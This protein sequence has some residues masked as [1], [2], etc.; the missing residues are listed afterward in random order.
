MNPLILLHP[1]LLRIYVVLV[2]IY[3]GMIFFGFIG[4]EIALPMWK[5]RERVLTIKEAM[6]HAQA[7]HYKA[8]LKVTYVPYSKNKLKITYPNGAFFFVKVDTSSGKYEYNE[9]KKQ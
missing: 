4:V 1:G 9:I 3:A 6:T 7:E 5:G 8:P 2:A